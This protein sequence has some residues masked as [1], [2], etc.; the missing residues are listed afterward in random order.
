MAFQIKDFVSIVASMLNHM[1]GTTTKITD[2]QPGSVART[3]V[4]APAVEIE[5]LYLQI[6]NGL[7]EAIP[8]ATFKSFG[9]DKLPPAF[10]RGFVS[11]SSPEP[12]TEDVDIAS[13]EQF[14]T[15]DGRG[16]TCSRHTLWLAGSTSVLVPV[17]ARQSGAQYNVS[18]GAISESPSFDD[19]YT[20]SNSA[21]NNGRDD[22]S[23][24]ERESRFA[25]FVAAL[26]RGTVY[27]CL[28][29]A[30]SIT[31]KDEAGNIQEYVTR[32]GIVEIA[33]YVRIF[34][35][36]S[37][38]SPSAQL[39]DNGQRVI[40]GW[41]DPITNKRTPGYRAGGVRIDVLPMTDKEI[42][43]SARVKMRAGYELTE[44]V[45]QSLLDEYVTILSATMPDDVLYVEMIENS[46][47][48]VANVQEVII[49]NAENR[50]CAASE[51]FVPGEFVV[52]AI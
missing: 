3:L 13:G 43:L 7:R 17:I 46:L 38:G 16:Y 10:A 15:P 44:S 32:S 39:I 50:T 33:G 29:A 18:S 12:L 40:D 22:E 42:P 49:L 23:D 41:K 2:Y 6:F 47:L 27:A 34:V 20:V 37:A 31:V 19:I 14:N 1:R 9:F 48:R 45:R 5:E 36:S 25:D 51:V 11:L 52:V 21:I 4:E 28:A 24:D 26:S 35:Y 8:V 30:E